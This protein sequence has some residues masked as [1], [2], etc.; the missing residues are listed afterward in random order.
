MPNRDITI[1]GLIVFTRAA[2]HT[3]SLS[4][5]PILGIAATPS[6]VTKSHLLDFNH[7]ARFI[8]KTKT[9]SS[10]MDHITEPPTRLE[11]RSSNR[12]QTTT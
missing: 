11:T 1:S 4:F 12:P 8:N 3:I 5:A 7:N 10:K 2:N 6:T 9:N